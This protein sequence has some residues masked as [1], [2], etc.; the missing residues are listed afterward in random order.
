M[1]RFSRFLR[2]IKGIFD[3]EYKLIDTNNRIYEG[4]P[5][6]VRSQKFFEIARNYQV[7]HGTSQKEAVNII[8]D[9][10][11]IKDVIENRSRTPNKQIQEILQD[12]Y[13]EQ[14]EFDL[15]IDIIVDYYE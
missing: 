5:Y 10:F 4:K 3:S 13:D 2:R 6:D 15:G 1:S 12:W 8:H 14:L 11:V 9:T 7:K